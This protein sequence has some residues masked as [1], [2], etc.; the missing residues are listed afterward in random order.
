MADDSEMQNLIGAI[1]EQ[2]NKFNYELKFNNIVPSIMRDC[3]TI[4]TLQ[5]ISTSLISRAK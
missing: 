5:Y 1:D 2:G 4:K 3:L